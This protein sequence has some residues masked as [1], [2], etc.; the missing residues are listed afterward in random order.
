MGQVERLLTPNQHNIKVHYACIE[1]RDF[2]LAKDLAGVHYSLFSVYGYIKDKKPGDSLK[3]KEGKFFTP[4]IAQENDKHVIMDSGLFT[5]M[6]GA[7]KGKKDRKFLEEWQDKQVQFVKENNLKCTCVEI[8]CQ[9]ILGVEEAW[10]FM[11]RMRALLPRNRIINVFHLEDGQKGLDR[12]IEFAEYIAISVPE[13]RIHQ[14][15]RYKENTLAFAHYIKNKKPEID[16][17]LLGCTEKDILERARFCTSCDS[18]SWT[19]G[20]RFG[21]IQGNRNE[22]IREDIKKEIEPRVLAKLK[23]YGIPP[24]ESTVQRLIISTVNAQVVK[25]QYIRMCGNQE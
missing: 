16:I 14:K 10:Y 1:N 25:K 13:L 19:Y 18:S 11:E 15:G 5:L 22:R 8:D 20:V 24:T 9:K 21:H 6:F 17:H 12:L 4:A 3:A 2:L 7:K 23:E